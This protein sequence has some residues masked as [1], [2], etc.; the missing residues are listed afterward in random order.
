MNKELLCFQTYHSML[1]DIFNNIE[2]LKEMKD[3]PT[4][5][6][7]EKYEVHFE[8]IRN[9]A[10]IFS[11]SLQFLP[12]AF[13]KNPEFT[14]NIL[15]TLI[16]KYDLWMEQVC[17]VEPQN[18]DRKLYRKIIG[19]LD[20]VKHMCVSLLNTDTSKQYVATIFNQIIQDNVSITTNNEE[21][22]TKRQLIG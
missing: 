4:T 11:I 14:T 20:E 12:Y 9:F 10:D 18:K 3:A 1:F 6:Q 15:Q 21:P 7:H 5:K 17:S 8:I 22:T 13:Y 16:N 19:L 2:I